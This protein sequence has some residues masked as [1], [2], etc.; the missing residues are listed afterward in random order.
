MATVWVSIRRGDFG[1]DLRSDKKEKSDGCYE[2]MW[3]SLQLCKRHSNSLQ[4]S[5]PQIAYS[6][7]SVHN[8]LV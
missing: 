4:R 6:V 8:V 5:K 3:C 1:M 2:P 7:K